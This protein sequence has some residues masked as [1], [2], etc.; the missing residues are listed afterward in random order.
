MSWDSADLDH[1]AESEEVRVGSYRADGR[2]RPLIPI[3]AVRVGT[4]LY[5][6]S[7]LGPEAG[8]FRR[9][10]AGTARLEAGGTGIDATLQPVADPAL[11]EQVSQAYRTK[12][13][14]HGSSLRTMVSAPAVDTTVRVVPR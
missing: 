11:N 10:M 7:A 9:A 13:H 2:L 4:D 5:V 3:W 1:L 12:Y 6:R 8:W 14:G